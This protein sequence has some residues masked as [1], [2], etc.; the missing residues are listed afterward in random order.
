M[1]EL[2]SQ[3]K[4]LSVRVAFCLMFL[5]GVNA[6]SNDLA[7]LNDEFDNSS[8]L[9]N[10]L[11][12]N[13]TEGWNA[14]Q[15]ETLDIDDTTAGNMVMMPFTVVWY[16]NYR[17]P[18]VYKEVTGDVVVTTAIHVTARDGVTVPASNFSLAGLMI[19][20][21]R[22]ITPATWTSGGENYVFFSLGH[23]SGSL[24]SFQYELKTTVNSSSSLFGPDTLENDVLLQIARVGDFVISLGKETD[25]PWIVHSRLNRSD[26]PE[27]IQVGAVAY[28][29]FEKIS[30]MD[31]FDHNANVL[32]P[33]L[34]INEPNPGQ[35]FNPDVI[36]TYDYI[37]FFRPTLPQDLV[38][39]DLTN[40]GSPDFVSDADLL[41]FLGESAAGLP[42]VVVG[43]TWVDFG[44]SGS[45]TGSE[46]TPFDTLGEALASLGGTTTVKI[47]GDT[48]TAVSSETLSIGQEVTIEAVNGAVRIGDLGA[49]SSGND[50]QS[51]F[52]SPE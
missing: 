18:L 9:S 23:R 28:T 26:M 49:R 42:V 1:F 6:S 50:T 44:F 10:W 40:A 27:T 24:S 14:D 45:E 15:L 12:V 20:T 21:P 30:G 39:L 41:A 29:N 47:K 51:G 46:S 48:G 37:R 19:R 7:P 25:Q 3:S 32:D 22:D 8:T 31:H 13:E 34:E 52:V 35:P 4:F 2:L 11:R 5:F 38:G 33:P 16:S 43:D 36:G 17:G